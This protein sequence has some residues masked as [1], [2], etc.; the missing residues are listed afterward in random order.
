[1]DKQ[2]DLALEHFIT[3]DSGSNQGL[4]MRI[5]AVCASF[6]TKMNVVYVFMK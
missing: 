3:K 1:M 4:T 6:H 5:C 2:L